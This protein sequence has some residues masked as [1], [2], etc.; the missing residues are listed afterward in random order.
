MLPD[1]PAYSPELNPAEHVWSWMV[2]FVNS[3]APSY[4]N[5]LKRAIRMAWQQLPQSTIQAYIDH[6]PT[7]CRQIIDAGGDH[8]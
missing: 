1:W 6:L 3:Q 2:R 8:V 4:R 5:Q 7:V